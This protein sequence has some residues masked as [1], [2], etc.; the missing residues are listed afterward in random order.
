MSIFS[1][2][3]VDVVGTVTKIL[4]NEIIGT[5]VRTKGGHSNE[6]GVTA[7]YAVIDTPALVSN[8][9]YLENRPIVSL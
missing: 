9:A 3:I 4:D 1:S 6:G 2:V 8:E 7:G 5:L